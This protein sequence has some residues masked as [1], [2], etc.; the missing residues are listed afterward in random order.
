MKKR[1]AAILSVLMMFFVSTTSSLACTGTYVGKDLTVNGSTIVARTEDIGGAHPKSLIAY[2]AMNYKNGD[3]FKDEINGFTWPMPERTYAY[4]G[5]PDSA[6]YDDDG[7]Y[8]EAGT[9]EKGVI[10]TATVSADYND[11]IA[12]LDPLVDDGLREASVATI[13]LQNAK[14]AREGIELVAKIVDEKGSAE[15]NIIMIADKNEAWYMEIVSGHQYAAIKLP[16]DVACVIPNC[17][18]LDYVDKNDKENVIVSNEL[19]SLPEQNN[20]VKEK[21]GRFSIRYTYAGEMDEYNQPRVCGG[22]NLLAPSKKLP[23]TTTDINLF[24]KPDKRLTVRDIMEL[25]KYRYEG[26]PIDA[27]KEENKDI[28]VIGTARQAECHIF[29]IRKEFPE[30]APSVMWLALGNAE[31]NI[32]V[33]FFNNIS[34]TPESY[35]MKSLEYD[36]NSAYWIFRALST[37]AELD[38]QQYGKG[39]REY[40]SIYQ[41][42]LIKNQEKIN[43]KFV[44]LYNESPEKA[45]GFAN[46][47]AAKLGNAAVD[48]A[49]IMYKE[50]MTYV[51]A[52]QARRQK[53]PFKTSLM[54]KKIEKVEETETVEKQV[55]KQVEETTQK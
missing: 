38:R 1:I 19:F 37:L 16:T 36:E 9:N 12:K 44:E 45:E 10:V 30:A 33:P 35:K 13:V 7:I 17:L 53:E 3:L 52:D 21:D 5:V 50:L 20:L 6:G 28:R 24:F 25:Q 23:Y 49:Q 41:D 48:K 32:Y 14:T 46:E 27:N 29:E 8:D 18:M 15:C 26:T 55:E 51:A 11:E 42:E 22:Q 4:Y 39:V 47:M 31:H 54:D 2:P 40:F 34:G 43:K